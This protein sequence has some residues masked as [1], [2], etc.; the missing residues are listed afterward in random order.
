[1]SHINAGATITINPQRL[2]SALSHIKTAA[3]A[4]AES[5]QLSPSHEAHLSHNLEA[6][7]SAATAVD[8]DWAA[9]SDVVSRDIGLRVDLHSANVT[10]VVEGVRRGLEGGGLMRHGKGACVWRDGVKYEGIDCGAI[11]RLTLISC[12]A[13]AQS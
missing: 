3:A 7:A 8:V 5:N 9:L 12:G 1:L 4:S 11:E 6:R 2:Q 10:F 13:R